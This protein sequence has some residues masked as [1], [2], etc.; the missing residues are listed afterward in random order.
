MFGKTDGF[1]CVYVG[2]ISREKRIDVIVNA[3]RELDNVYL[4]VIGNGATAAIYQSMHGAKNRLYCKPEFLS[5]DELA[6][7]YAS[8]DLHVSAS[9]FE[10][11]VSDFYCH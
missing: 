6:E 10:T 8:S 4:A 1:L 5:H 7:I 2:R 9:E 3:V 11:L